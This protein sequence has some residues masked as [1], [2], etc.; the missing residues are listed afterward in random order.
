MLSTSI[1][2]RPDSLGPMCSSPREARGIESQSV[3]LKSIVQMLR[4]TVAVH[5]EKLK[6]FVASAPRSA[7]CD[8]APKTS[9]SPHADMLSGLC[10]ELESLNSDLRYLTDSVDI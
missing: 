4:E 1:S 9:Y 2:S 5:A 7:G 10:E 8:G 3:R 6:P